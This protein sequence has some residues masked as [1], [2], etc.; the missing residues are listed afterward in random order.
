M[1][2]DEMQ[3]GQELDALIATQI[4]GFKF[5]AVMGGSD[6]AAF[7]ISIPD[8]ST[9]IAAAWRVMEKFHP[10]HICYLTRLQSG[11][12]RVDLSYI[13]E[14]FD[15]NINFSAYDDAV[16]LAICRAALKAVQENN[17]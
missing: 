6:L 15:D 2:V 8:Y 17:K 7:Y 12:W 3:A 11:A 4:M 9:D 14:D 16:S 13:A 1:N 10:S 5:P